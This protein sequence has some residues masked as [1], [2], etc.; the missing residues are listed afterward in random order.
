M[1]EHIY[2]PRWRESFNKKPPEKYI[3]N[4][5]DYV[6]GLDSNPELIDFIMHGFSL[7]DADRMFYLIR[8]E[9]LKYQLGI[10][11]KYGD[12]PEE[13]EMCER[14]IDDLIENYNEGAP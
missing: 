10:M 12:P 13:I 1:A 4:Y 8:I 6:Y 3:E 14:L 2:V 9:G 11:K 7:R 5:I